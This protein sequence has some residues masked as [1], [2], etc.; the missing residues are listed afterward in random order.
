MLRLSQILLHAAW[1]YQQASICSDLAGRL[2]LWVGLT[3]LFF[4]ML[5]NQLVASWLKGH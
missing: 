4:C 1:A 2:G 3:S 5:S